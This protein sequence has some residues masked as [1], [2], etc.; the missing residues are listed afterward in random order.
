MA[1]VVDSVLIYHASYTTPGQSPHLDSYHTWTARCFYIHNSVQ[2]TA[3]NR[4]KVTL[5]TNI[6]TQPSTER[7][8]ARNIEHV[9]IAEY[10]IIAWCMA[11]AASRPSRPSTDMRVTWA[12]KK[13]K[14]CSP[15]TKKLRTG[16]ETQVARRP[17]PPSPPTV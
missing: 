2:H 11:A 4:G 17:L 1:Q 14:K 6:L 3:Q 8:Q 9:P 12:R 16:K 13:A 5:S 15:K 7:H 10:L